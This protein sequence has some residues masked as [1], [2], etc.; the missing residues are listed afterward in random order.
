M[1]DV[2][3]PTGR[4][5][6]AGEQ[7]TGKDVKE[8]A[9]G[10]TQQAQQKAQE[11]TQ[12]VKEQAQEKA[13]Q[14]RGQASDRLR[15]Q[16]DTRSTQTGEQVTSLADAMR[17]TGV[18]L[19]S[20]GKETPAKLTDQTAERA[21]RLGSYLRD[22]DADRILGDVEAFARRQPWAFAAGG[23]A[24]G[25]VLSRFLKASSSRR[26]QSLDSRSRMGLPS[27][28]PGVSRQYGGYQ[29]PL[30]A[31]KPTVS[32]PV[33]TATGRPYASDELDLEP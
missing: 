4:L 20:E 1:A 28:Y 18:Q 32:T 10:A 30:A 5:E 7:S 26:Y 33:G 8:K 29:P 13:Q 21:E 6:Q 23:L 3:D 9:K 16:V 27:G 2:R 24:L 17:K 19:R 15:Q 25:F 14:V 31:D 11:T 12:Q 22:S